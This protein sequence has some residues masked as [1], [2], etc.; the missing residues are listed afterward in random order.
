M[1][2]IGALHV[3]LIW[4]VVHSPLPLDSLPLAGKHLQVTTSA[5]QV[6]GAF[7]Q[8]GRGQCSAASVSS[9]LPA[10]GSQPVVGEEGGRLAPCQSF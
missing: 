2:T 3:E 8:V 7:E 1:V 9:W 6:L 4:M 5:E 10:T